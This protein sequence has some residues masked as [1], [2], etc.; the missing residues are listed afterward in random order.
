MK[1]ALTTWKMGTISEYASSQRE[2]S[3]TKRKMTYVLIK[4]V[5]W[6][7]SC[8]FVFGRIS[9]RI[10]AD[11]STLLANFFV[12]YLSISF[13]NGCTAVLLGPGRFFSVI[14]FFTRTVGF[15]GQSISPSQGRYLHT[16]QHKHNKGIQTSIP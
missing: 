15:L 14:I 7:Y 10:L 11:I 4:Q 6:R 8:V 5:G 13:I 12:V 3:N 9:V 2:T 16:E 1:H